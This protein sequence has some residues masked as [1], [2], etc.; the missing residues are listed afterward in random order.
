MKNSLPQEYNNGFFYKIKIFFRN[1]FHKN[2]EII[3]DDT[4][5]SQ[6]K[7]KIVKDNRDFVNELKVDSNVSINFA[8][9]ED[10]ILQRIE[11][12]PDLLNDLSLEKLDEIEKIYDEKIAKLDANINKISIQNA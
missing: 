8:E 5:V 6:T 7:T 2:K 10:A 1:L 9:K 12:N 11:E 3:K 4:S